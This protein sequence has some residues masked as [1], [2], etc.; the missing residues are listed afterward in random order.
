MSHNTYASSYATIGPACLQDLLASEEPGPGFNMDHSG[1]RKN[2]TQ[3]ISQS[4]MT[5]INLNGAL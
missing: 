5:E 2:T 4:I 3:L 1:T